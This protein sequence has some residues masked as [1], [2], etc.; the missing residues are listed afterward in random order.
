MPVASPRGWALRNG[1]PKSRIGGVAHANVAHKEGTLAHVHRAQL[2]DEDAGVTTLV[3]AQRGAGRAIGRRFD[4]RQPR[5]A[6]GLAIGRS[7]GRR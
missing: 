7:E 2:I 3:G 5:R 4:H 6:L 1:P